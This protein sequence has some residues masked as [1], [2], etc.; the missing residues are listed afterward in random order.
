MF[1]PKTIDPYQENKP[2]ELH[3]QSPVAQVQSSPPE[4]IPRKQSGNNIIGD[5]RLNR[6]RI[7][8][9]DKKAFDEEKMLIE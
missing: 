1:E 8:L 7:S 9:V 4:P 3:R 6:N 2:I 5:N